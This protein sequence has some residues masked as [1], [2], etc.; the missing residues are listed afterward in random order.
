[1]INSDVATQRQAKIIA[2][3]LPEVLAQRLG[4]GPGNALKF[5]LQTPTPNFQ[6]Q[7]VVWELG[8]GSW[9]LLT[10]HPRRQHAKA[11]YAFRSCDSG[12]SLRARSRNQQPRA[13]RTDPSRAF[14][15][16][17]CTIAFVRALRDRFVTP[18]RAVDIRRTVVGVAFLRPE[19]HASATASSSACA[20]PARVWQHRVR[21]VPEQRD[22]SASP[23]LYRI[24]IQGSSKR[25]SSGR[26][27][28][29]M[30]RM[31]SS[32]ARAAVDDGQRVP[33]GTDGIIRH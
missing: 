17:T 16:A 10:I 32:N 4:M 7:R 5:E 1:M 33:L 15:R 24:A 30:A 6:P 23:P 22:R 28:E 27:A 19:V 26:V 25:A 14:R 8:I 31:R 20:A 3:G 9:E 18:Q 12:A 11:T 21:G 2:A 29:T 13:L